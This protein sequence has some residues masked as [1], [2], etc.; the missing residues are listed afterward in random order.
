MSKKSINSHGIE[1]YETK[2]GFYP[3]DKET[4]LKLKALFKE[5]YRSLSEMAKWGR[6]DRKMPQNR[7]MKKKI[8]DTNGRV[9]GREVIG[10]M[11]EPVYS[12]IFCEK[13]TKEGYKWVY[14]QCGGYGRETYNYE[15]LVSKNKDIIEAY[16][17]ASSIK[18]S[19]D[20]VTKLGVSLE[21]IDELYK[22][23]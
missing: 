5:W 8:R 19:A 7:V 1:V 9:I 10:P 16:W 21:K 2:Y 23:L 13:Q 20:E 11:P 18:R 12:S 4:M 22:S 6:W 14:E 15:V 3:C 17:A